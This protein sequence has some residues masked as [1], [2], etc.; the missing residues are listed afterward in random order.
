LEWSLYVGKLS[1]GLYVRG[2][3]FIGV[4]GDYLEGWKFEFAWFFDREG[5]QYVIGRCE[6]YE[7]KDWFAAAQ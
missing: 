6:L 7:Q 4:D 1:I 3:V 2:E 5:N